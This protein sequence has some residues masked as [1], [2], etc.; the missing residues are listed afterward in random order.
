MLLW[1]EVTARNRAAAN[2]VC[3]P[4][5]DRERSALI[6]I[7]VIQ[8]AGLTPHG[9]ERNAYAPSRAHIRFVMYAID[10]GGGT[11]LFANPVDVGRVTQRVDIGSSHVGGKHLA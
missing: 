9:Q 4:S 1:K 5:P 10:G 6:S 2:V 3:Q 11:I 8:W 7:P